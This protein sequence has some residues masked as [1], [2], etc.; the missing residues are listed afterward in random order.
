MRPTVGSEARQHDQLPAAPARSGSQGGGGSSSTT[1]AAEAAKKK[2]YAR[3]SIEDLTSEVLRV[4]QAS[5]SVAQQQ[6]EA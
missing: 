5:E 4:L 1:A 3:G 2:R 6:E